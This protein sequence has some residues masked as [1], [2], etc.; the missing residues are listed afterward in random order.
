MKIVARREVTRVERL[1]GQGIL[2]EGQSCVEAR[3]RVEWWGWGVRRSFPAE[4]AIFECEMGIISRLISGR[5]YHSDPKTDSTARWPRFATVLWSVSAMTFDLA[6]PD[7]IMLVNSI[8]I[9]QGRV[10]HHWS[11]AKPSRNGLRCPA[12]CQPLMQGFSL[13]PKS[14]EH[15]TLGNFT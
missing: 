8:D 12:L 11:G 14:V 3:L 1:L 6:L 5:Q 13:S 9:T 2:R 15:N 4:V 10:R 7:T